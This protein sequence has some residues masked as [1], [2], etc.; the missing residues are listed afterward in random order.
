MSVQAQDPQYVGWHDA[1]NERGTITILWT[2]LSTIIISTWTI[3][4]LNIPRRD[5]T[6][7]QKTIRKIKWMCVT[8]LFP[9][10]TFAKAVCE[11]QMAVEDLFLLRDVKEDIEKTGWKVEVGRV[12]RIL[13]WF[14]HPLKSRD[15]PPPEAKNIS[16]ELQRPE[17]V[18]HE[19]GIESGSEEPRCDDPT[20]IPRPMKATWTLTHSYFA[21]MGGIQIEKKIHVHNCCEP[22]L[23]KN[24]LTT[25]IL[26]KC[27]TRTNHSLFL[28][29]S[30]SKADIED[31]SK[32]NWLT[33]GI[34]I[35]QISWLIISIC[36]RKARS[37]TISQ[38]EVCTVAFAALATA[39]WLANWYK[40]KDIER[41][42]TI[43]IGNE[44]I[45]DDEGRGFCSIYMD[46]YRRLST[47]YHFSGD[48]PGETIRNDYVRFNNNSTTVAY[49]VAVSA[50]F[51]G[52]IHLLAWNSEFPSRTEATIWKMAGILT[53]TIP[54]VSIILVG[55]NGRIVN[56]QLDDMISALKE[57][58][59]SSNTEDLFTEDL[60]KNNEALQGNHSEELDIY[61]DS[62]WFNVLY[63]VCRNVF[64][65]AHSHRELERFFR[66][67]ES[68]SQDPQRP[69]EF[70]LPARHPPT[71]RDELQF[72]I[73]L[74]NG[75][76]HRKVAIRKFGTLWQRK[77]F[78]S[79]AI[80]IITGFSYSVFRIMM[81]AV[82]LAALRHQDE[83]LYLNT[84]TKN[85]PNIS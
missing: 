50:T 54:L 82:A 2:C 30:I 24:C 18:D 35:A 49:L 45:R 33:K 78:I 57:F 75:E 62:V 70:K 36:A 34:A 8:I 46:V 51:F 53:T 14:F 28:R 67:W 41:P 58:A 37:L 63:D 71:L 69:A 20:P 47:F 61:I 16:N 56:Q 76:E 81:L 77:I 23:V 66:C 80:T 40:P 13:H 22:F 79:G 55:I 42:I 65:S 21:N 1:P 7:V 17:L 25:F 4:H 74:A 31:K 11:L 68:V 84:W 9:E 73:N 32:A 19:E 5:D 59:N 43:D 6:T 44:N 72:M 29:L 3:L 85:L 48:Y 10:I 38:I 15:D 64:G 26:A 12:A 27:C 83:R 39:T 60:F 52:G